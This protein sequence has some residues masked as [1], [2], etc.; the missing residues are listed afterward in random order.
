MAA[1]VHVPNNTFQLLL[2]YPKGFPAQTVHMNPSNKSQQV[3]FS[4][5][6]MPGKS[7]MEGTQEEAS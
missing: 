2:W 1:D 6:D 7:P 3:V 5:M 4:Y